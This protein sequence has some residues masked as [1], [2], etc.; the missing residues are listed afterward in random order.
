MEIKPNPMTEL[1]RERLMRELEEAKQEV[2]AAGRRAGEAASQGDLRENAAYDQA[3]DEQTLARAR[4]IFLKESLLKSYI[5]HSRKETSTIDLGN[6]VTFEFQDGSKIEMNILGRE[7]GG[8]NNNWL[9]Y[10]TPLG[11]AVLGKCQGNEVNLESGKVKILKI[12][13]GDFER[14]S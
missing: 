5:L 4:V 2:V 11:Q 1:T 9:S 8:T 7:D 6:K 3:R 10:N 13:P 12:E 14:L